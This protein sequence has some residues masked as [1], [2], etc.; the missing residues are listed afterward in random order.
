MAIVGVS[1]QDTGAVRRKV[2]TIGVVA[3][4]AVDYNLGRRLAGQTVN[5]EA[6]S[7]L[8]RFFCNGEL[9]K[10]YRRPAHGDRR[11]QRCAVALA[12]T[13]E[14]IYRRR[15]HAAAGS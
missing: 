9:V 7:E 10:V 3:F 8:V 14:V 5:V 4:A 2:S 12:G 11:Y 15:K 1:E 13:G 6:D